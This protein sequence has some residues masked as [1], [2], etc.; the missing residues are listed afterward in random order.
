MRTPAANALQANLVIAVEEMIAGALRDGAIRN[1]LA[2]D[3]ISTLITQTVH[4]VSR[5]QPPAH[6]LADAYL[7]V[8]TACTPPPDRRL[9]RESWSRPR[10]AS[11]QP[12]PHSKTQPACGTRPGDLPTQSHAVAQRTAGRHRTR[13]NAAWVGAPRW[14][15]STAKTTWSK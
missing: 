1:D 2:P 5:T 15:S 7:T 8:L 3:V 6:D 9:V 4:A 10:D 12:L 11:K 14:P 13:V